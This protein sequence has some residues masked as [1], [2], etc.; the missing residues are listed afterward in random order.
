[1]N[2]HVRIGGV[3]YRVQEALVLGRL[4]ALLRID[5]GWVSCFDLDADSDGRQAAYWK[6]VGT[7]LAPLPY[8][9]L[10]FIEAPFPKVCLVE[11]VALTFGEG[12][13]RIDLPKLPEEGWTNVVAWMTKRTLTPAATVSR[14]DRVSIDPNSGLLY[15]VAK[16][17][18]ERIWLDRKCRSRSVAVGSPFKAFRTYEP[19]TDWD[20]VEGGDFVTL[21]SVEGVSIVCN[22]LDELNIEFK[23]GQRIQSAPITEITGLAK[24]KRFF[25]VLVDSI[26][27]EVESPIAG[28][29]LLDQSKIVGNSGAKFLVEAL[30][31][32]L[33]WVDKPD[34]VRR[35][36]ANTARAPIH[37]VRSLD[38]VSMRQLPQVTYDEQGR[39]LQKQGGT[40]VDAHD[41]SRA[42]KSRRV[43]YCTLLSTATQDLMT[44]SLWDSDYAG[45]KF[46]TTNGGKLW[47]PQRDGSWSCP[48][49]GARR[50]RF[51]YVDPSRGKQ[52]N[53]K[54]YLWG[55]HR[56]GGGIP[57]GAVV[58]LAGS[59]KIVKVVSQGRDNLE[60]MSSSRLTSWVSE[61]LVNLV[62]RQML[63]EDL[64]TLWRT[65]D[66]PP[67][68]PLV[69]AD[70]YGVVWLGV[71][72]EDNRIGYHPSGVK[73]KIDNLDAALA[74]EWAHLVEAELRRLKVKFDSVLALPSSRSLDQLYQEESPGLFR[75]RARERGLFGGGRREED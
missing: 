40:L 53:R 3:A 65:I 55:I 15:H 57:D 48:T 1:M 25:A 43:R 8:R 7:L 13:T 71:D 17:D 35:D 36:V 2:E 5:S 31:E 74:D 39:V 21:E 70:V 19:S 67:P 4:L 59:M 23:N 62:C 30:D 14:G 68:T 28:D 50:H 73:L 49:D 60:V 45:R 26:D 47:F 61:N 12:E 44:K 6:D 27:V 16:V 22:R 38:E 24:R 75:A 10:D 52:E 64:D 29:R 54:V 63:D 41:Y 20:A 46:I 51:E 42:P 18:S 58:R 69:R 9:K 72:K 32:Q 34:R 37:L 66:G 56:L 11:D 33:V